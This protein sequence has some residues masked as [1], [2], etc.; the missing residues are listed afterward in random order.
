[1]P[2]SNGWASFNTE[3]KLMATHYDQDIPEVLKNSELEK[4]LPVLP[5]FKADAKMIFE[6]P[7]FF[8]DSFTQTLEP[9]AQ[10]LYVPYKTRQYQ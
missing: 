9:R 6:R 3:A 4:M 5:Q 8:N 2:L 1:M 10:Y 7:M